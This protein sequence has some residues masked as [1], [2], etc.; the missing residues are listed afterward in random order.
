MLIGVVGRGGGG[1][2]CH[3]ILASNSFPRDFYT[4]NIIT[5][6]EKQKK[7]IYYSNEF[8]HIQCEK[9]QLVL[10]PMA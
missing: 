1:R 3:P 5:D 10:Y 4:L 8:L 2:H 6:V 7:S 9:C